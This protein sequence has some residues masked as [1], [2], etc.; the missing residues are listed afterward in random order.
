MFR[1]FCLNVVYGKNKQK[2]DP[3]KFEGGRFKKHIKYS[4]F[5]FDLA[6]WSSHISFLTFPNTKCEFLL[7][8]EIKLNKK[9]IKKMKL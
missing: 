7:E 1:F 4:C 3:L 6:I 5:Y 2:R 8:T 9:K